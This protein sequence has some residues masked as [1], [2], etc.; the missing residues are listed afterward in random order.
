VKASGRNTI[1]PVPSYDNLTAFGEF[2]DRM[3]EEG[4]WLMYDMRGTFM[5]LSSVREQVEMFKNYPNML[6][7][8]TGDEPD[9]WGYP[10]NST[11]QAGDLIE[12]LDPYHP[13]SL[14]LNCFDYFFEEYTQGASVIM[15]DTYAVDIN[16]TFS[17]EWNTTCNAT[18]GDCGCDDCEG[19][20]ADVATRV[21]MFNE[22]LSVDGRSRG[23][24]V[25]SVP[26][27]F[28]NET[29]WPRYPTPQ[30]FIL[31]SI[32]ALNHGSTGIISWD[33]DSNIPP[34]LLSSASILGAALPN[35]T[36]VIFNP[37]V[38][39]NTVGSSS[40]D[41]AAWSLPGT[42]GKTE[43]VMILG[44]NI[45]SQNATALLG[46]APSAGATITT[47]LNTGAELIE[48]NGS[49]S[50]IFEGLGSI[51]FLMDF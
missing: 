11:K 1:H 35:I 44:T 32:I 13:V 31:Q 46:P 18:L 50:I 33:E 23:V 49:L 41:I 6:L 37:N 34:A 47:L 21:D 20:F 17:R 2:L 8:Y 27:G 19:S 36:S 25:W 9:G 16:A 12:A 24:S 48:K 43:R 10:H 14:V 4:L 26:Q 7:W 22:R 51:G 28:G 15:Q 40:V 30:E 29:Y 42:G 39:R 38:R 45:Q 5:N 3:K